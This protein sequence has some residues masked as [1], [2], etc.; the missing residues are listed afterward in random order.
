MIELSS[1]SVRF[2]AG[3]PLSVCALDGLSLSV[4]RGEFISVIGSNGAG[5]STLLSCL[6]GDIAPSSGRVIIDDLDVTHFPTERRAGMVSRVF[7]DPLTGT[8]GSLTIEENMA[9]SMDRG[10][11]RGLGLAL[12]SHKRA[13]FRAELRR[14]GLGLEDRLGERVDRLSGGQRQALSLLLATLC[15]ARVFLLDEHTAALDPRMSSFVMDLTERLVSERG[16][17]TIM[18]THSLVQALRYGSRLVMLDGGRIVF[19]S[20][21]AERSRLTVEDLV[22]RF[23]RSRGELSL[24]SDELLLS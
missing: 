18:V 11:R 6:A 16:L 23:S 22:S 3:T 4:S 10:R 24:D 8:C 19:E 14:L 21:G 17:T 2:G 12:S 9:L 7:Q 15:E 1:I 13:H 20:S 5:K